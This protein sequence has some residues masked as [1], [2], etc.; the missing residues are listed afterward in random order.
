MANRHGRPTA[1]ILSGYRSLPKV[2]GGA[3]ALYLLGGY[4]AFEMQKGWFE[5][6]SEGLNI[7]LSS[8]SGGS[9][10]YDL[11]GWL[12]PIVLA[13]IAIGFVGLLIQQLFLRTRKLVSSSMSSRSST[14]TSSPMTTSWG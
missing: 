10:E 8:P 12:V 13:A 1:E 14:F 3:A 4:L 5:K 2:L 11:L 9:S 6:E 7:S